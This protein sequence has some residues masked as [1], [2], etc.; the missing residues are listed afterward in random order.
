MCIKCPPGPKTVFGTRGGTITVFFGDR[1]YLSNGSRFFGDLKVPKYS[2]GLNKMTGPPATPGR[3]HKVP[4]GTKTDFGSNCLQWLKVFLGS[5]SQLGPYLINTNKIRA[6]TPWLEVWG[7][8]EGGQTL[9][10]GGTD[11]T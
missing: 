4:P 8:P 1:L 3:G 11:F 5:K 2:D 7:G 10:I 6:G 9:F